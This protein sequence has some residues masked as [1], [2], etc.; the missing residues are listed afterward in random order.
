M[1]H[2]QIYITTPSGDVETVCT[3]LINTNIVDS[4]DDHVN[5]REIDAMIGLVSIMSDMH[6]YSSGDHRM[7]IEY[8]MNSD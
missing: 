1:W 3:R 5:V 4:Q 7:S 8:I 6:G 2:R